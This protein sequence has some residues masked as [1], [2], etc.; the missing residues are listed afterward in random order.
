MFL[1]R[2]VPTHSYYLIFVQSG[3]EEAYSRAA[4]TLRDIRQHE[5]RSEQ[6]ALFRKRKNMQSTTPV[7]WTH[8]FICLDKT[9]SDRVPTTQS[10]KM[11]LEEAG[12]GEKLIEVPDVD[13]GPD[14]FNDVVLGAY[15]KL[16]EGGGYEMLRCKPASRDLLLIGP[17]IAS[18]PKLL[19]RRVGS[20]KVYLRPLQRDLSLDIE[21]DGDDVKGVSILLLYCHVPA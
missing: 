15:P 16:K 8:K 21:E 2:V 20:G 7:S 14:E 3:F 12:L 10:A 6:G 5:V 9:D 18:T 19:K 1:K 13:C 11:V 17:R 4:S